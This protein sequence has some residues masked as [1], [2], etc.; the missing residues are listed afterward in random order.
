[1]I[2][3][4][5]VKQPVSQL[6]LPADYPKL[7][8]ELK[9]RIIEARQ[10]A[11][12]SANAVLI[13]LYWEIGRDILKRQKSE[14]WGS[15]VI[16]R[17]AS[18]LG[19]A[20]PDMKGLSPRNLKFMRAFAEAY[21]DGQIVKQVVSQIPWGHN[22]RILQKIKE[23]DQRL[24]Y[25][26]AAIENGW[27]R[28]VLVHQIENDIFSRKGSA[29]TNFKK[30]LP[31]PQ[32]DLAQ[33]TLKDPYVF[34]F[35]ILDK[36]FR[37]RELEKAL[38]EH[39]RDFLI[40]LG[41]GF[42]YVGNQYHMEIGDKDFYIDLLFYHLKLRCYVV[43]DLKSGDFKPEYTGKMNFYL[44]A[45]DD[46][47]NKDQDNPAIGII[48]CKTRNKVIAEYALRDMNKPIGISEYK[49]IDSLPKE[50]KSSLPTV[51]DIEQELMKDKKHS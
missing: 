7:L 41:V 45:V 6:R 36:D 17:L 42:A 27:S 13:N 51:E 47:L 24:W 50:F 14:G 8:E 1:M 35:L 5:I 20:F 10:K 2:N 28:N 18:D 34:D 21:P 46:N 15:K 31:S 22:I 12:L 49:L 39:L 44:S 30:T 38:N 4:R 40:E 9:H 3:E 43:I 48:L 25:A 19:K 37:E 26:K 33:Q 23:P 11:S 29:I 16:D 32:S